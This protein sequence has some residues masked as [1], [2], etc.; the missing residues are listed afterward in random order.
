MYPMP[1]IAASWD[2]FVSELVFH[3]NEKPGDI[4]KMPRLN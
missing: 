3:E 4:T 1:L 2:A